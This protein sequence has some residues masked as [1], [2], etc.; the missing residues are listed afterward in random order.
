LGGILQ[1]RYGLT[2]VRK[3]ANRIN[4]N[5]VEEEYIDGDE[6]GGG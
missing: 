6:V 4:F 5:Q 3:A 1:C 2:D